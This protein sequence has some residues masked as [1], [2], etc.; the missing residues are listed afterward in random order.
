MAEANRAEG[1][2]G[3]VSRCTEYVPT[4]VEIRDG[5]SDEGLRHIVASAGAMGVWTLCGQWIPIR[6]LRILKVDRGA[7]TMRVRDEERRIEPWE[8][9]DCH[10]ACGE[11][12]L[13]EKRRCRIGSGPWA[14]LWH[15]PEPSTPVLTLAEA[16]QRLAALEAVEKA[17]RASW[18]RRWL[19]RKEKAA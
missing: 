5:Q 3:G 15:R 8:W 6:R 13:L 7:H 10:R 18:W 9:S 14:W 19:A 1:E 12:H 2:G 11:R 16:K 17:P 4:V